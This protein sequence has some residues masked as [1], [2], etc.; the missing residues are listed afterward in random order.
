MLYGGIEGWAKALSIVPD[1]V[2]LDLMLPGKNGLG[3]IKDLKCEGYTN[4]VSMMMVTAR[5]ETE[6]GISGFEAGADDYLAKPFSSKE[7]LLRVQAILKRTKRAP[8]TSIFEL[9]ELRFSKNR[10]GG[11][12]VCGCSWLL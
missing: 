8:G 12:F 5:G 7:F 9:S 4:M 10:M 2:I 6:D 11:R 1:L 3:V